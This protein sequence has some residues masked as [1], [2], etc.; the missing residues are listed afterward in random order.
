MKV[1]GAL[2]RYLSSVAVMATP[3]ANQEPAGVVKNRLSRIVSRI[4]RVFKR[5]DRN[6]PLPPEVTTIEAA[7]AA[8]EVQ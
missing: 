2:G 8:R 6:A 5:S 7:P 1:N 4:K 3:P